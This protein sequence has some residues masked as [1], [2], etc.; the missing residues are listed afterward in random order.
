[1]KTC[2]LNPCVETTCLGRQCRDILYLD[3]RIVTLTDESNS[4]VIFC[5]VTLCA[6][7]PCVVTPCVGRTYVAA[8]CVVKSYFVATCVVKPVL[9]HPVF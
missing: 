6:L 1:M 8:P 9:R 2:V 7:N 4:V 5:I 3:T